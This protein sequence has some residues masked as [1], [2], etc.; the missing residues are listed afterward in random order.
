[1]CSRFKLQYAVCLHQQVLCS[2]EEV[3]N[4]RGVLCD[5]TQEGPLRRNPGNH[6]HDVVQGLPTSA[7]V[8]F[9]LGLTNYDTGA[10]DRSSNMSF[11]NTLEGLISSPNALL[12]CGLLHSIVAWS[13]INSIW[14]DVFDNPVGS[15]NLL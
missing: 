10:M 13:N 15:N 1:M 14:L 8:E 4:N 6:N 9:T 2:R 5:A 12:M 11:R 3:Y 7:E